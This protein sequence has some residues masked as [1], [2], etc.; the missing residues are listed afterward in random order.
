MFAMMNE[1]ERRNECWTFG[2]MYMIV[3]NNRERKIKTRIERNE[4]LK[5]IEILR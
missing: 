3:V 4:R 5:K 2:K 1:V